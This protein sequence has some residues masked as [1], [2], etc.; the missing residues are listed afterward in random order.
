MQDKKEEIIE[1]S[2][3]MTIDNDTP[4]KTVLTCKEPARKDTAV[5]TIT[6]TNK[7]GS[8][9]ADLEVVVLGKLY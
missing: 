2:A 8:D 1:P 4:K 9:S 7:H 6:V 3:D 5:Y